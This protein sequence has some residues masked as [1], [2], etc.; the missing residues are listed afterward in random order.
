MHRFYFAHELNGIESVDRKNKG[1]KQER[2]CMTL[3]KSFVAM[4]LRGG[5]NKVR[6]DT[7]I[8]ASFN[9]Y[10]HYII[11]YLSRMATKKEIISFATL[12]L[13]LVHSSGKLLI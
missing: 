4:E 7:L 13:V 5:V 12:S 2:L 9:K 10:K 11:K 3:W 6:V 1:A 8:K